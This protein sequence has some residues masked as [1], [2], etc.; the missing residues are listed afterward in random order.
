MY[1]DR[2]QVNAKIYIDWL[3]QVQKQT[4]TGSSKFKHRH[5]VARVSANNRHRL[6]QV[7]ANID[8]DW[9]K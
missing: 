1:I 9:L 7:S 6:A 2:A 5:R 4:Q 8:I 3:K